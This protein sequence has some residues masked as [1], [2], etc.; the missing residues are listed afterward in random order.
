VDDSKEEEP[1]KI[2]HEIRFGELANL[3]RIPHTPYYGTIDATPLFLVLMVELL[4]WTGDL[5]ILSELAPNVMAAL[6]W[7]DRYGDSDGDGFVEYR[8]SSA[9]WLRNQGWKDSSDSLIA[10]DGRPAPVP[11]ALVEVQGYVYQAK[12]GLA[13]IFRH[14]GRRAEADRLAREA[15]ELRRRF[16]R[17][18]WVPNRRYL[19]QA[20][21][22]DKRQV[23]AITSNAGHALWSGVVEP[24]RAAALVE[25][26]VTPEMFSG[27]G[28]RTLSSD[29]ISFN[30]MSYHN[31]SIWPHDNSIIAAG[32]RRYGYRNEPE[33]VARSVLEACMRFSDHRLPELFCGFSR[34]RRFDSGPGEYLVSCS[35]QAWAAAALFHFLQ[36]LIGVQ[37]RAFE[38]KLR[39]DPLDTGLYKRLRVEGMRVGED[40]IDFT[41][42]RRGGRPTVKVDRRPAGL[43]LELPA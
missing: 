39:I 24:A 27:W 2:L 18:F 36:T 22:G 38:G 1:G 41:V 34:D 43:K 35:P 3:K 11:A 37:V 28:V 9:V 21:D 40:E 4:D 16:N 5:D 14:Q 7:V 23:P 31:G 29:W 12:A 15:R 8:P 25:R 42:D 20:L 33:L 10:A 26:L 6:E 32:M 13:R 17:A 19:A 30:P